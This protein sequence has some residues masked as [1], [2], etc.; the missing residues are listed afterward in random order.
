MAKEKRLAVIELED[1]ESGST[2]KVIV[3]L[4]WFEETSIG[5]VERRVTINEWTGRW[6][7]DESEMPY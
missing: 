3:D 4:H 6:Y 7:Y 5:V 2:Y 1:Q